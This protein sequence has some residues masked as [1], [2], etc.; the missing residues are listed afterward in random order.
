MLGDWKSTELD[1]Q[2][3]PNFPLLV[4]FL[5]GGLAVLGPAPR[6]FLTI[7]IVLTALKNHRLTLGILV[8]LIAVLPGVLMDVFSSG[9]EGEEVVGVV[10][11]AGR[12]HVILGDVRILS[13]NQWR[14]FPRKVKILGENTSHP[15]D[16][17]HAIVKEWR[18][19]NSYPKTTIMAER[20]GSAY[21]PRGFYP[22]IKRKSYELRSWISRLL[23]GYLGRV[24]YISK[25]LLLGE[26][27]EES[28]IFR[29]AG[30]SHFF[31][32]SGF[33]VYILAGLLVLPLRLF[34]IPRNWRLFLPVV[35]LWLYLWC[36]DFPA[37]AA[38]AVGMIT[39]Y[40]LF[41]CIDYSVQPL[42]ILGAIGLVNLAIEPE[43]AFSASFVLSYFATFGILTIGINVYS[44]MK[45][46][47][48]KFLAEGFAFTFGAQIMVL[49]V[50]TFFFNKLYPYAFLATLGLVWILPFIMLGTIFLLVFHVLGVEWLAKI[51]ANGTSLI[52]T[53]VHKTA[54]F[55][56][57]LPLGTVQIES[58]MAVYLLLIIS[59]SALIF[60]WQEGHRP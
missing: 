53:A 30:I 4:A 36:V 54:G 46:S 14:S 6:F 43:Q 48:L 1:N 17:V 51:I 25:G 3:Q 24:S 28:E 19:E 13:K 10:V 22:L 33:H 44:R 2:Y 59:V 31:A 50:S 32:V 8:G 49:P 41:K 55:L 18:S 52:G 23:D 34:M 26:K 16:V 35:V 39:L 7:L 37:S 15:G 11:N 58:R 9:I 47:R 56:A 60:F 21:L 20:I 12:N 40:S 38:R 5:S 45:A 29:S 27:S 42:N 57:E